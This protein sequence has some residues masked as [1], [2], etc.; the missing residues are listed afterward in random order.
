MIL[1]A[2]TNY[3]KNNDGLVN[4]FTWVG[5][6][7][8]NELITWS[9]GSNNFSAVFGE[10]LA[11]TLMWAILATFTNYFLGMFVAIMIN[12]KGIKFKKLWRGLLV[13]TIAIPQF[14][15]LIYVS[16]LFDSNGII[17]GFL[18]NNN[19]IKE[20]IPFWTD[21]T[22]A[23]IM[24]VLINIWV[25]VPYL[26]L[27]TTGVLMNIPADLYESAKIDGANAFQQYVKITLPYMLFVTGPYLL[28]SFIGNLNNFNVIFLLTGGAPTKIN[29]ATSGGSSGETDLLITWLFKITT[30]DSN[31]KLASVI[32]IIIFIIVAV[33]SLVVYNIMPSNK[34]EEDYS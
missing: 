10:I 23:R 25:G 29:G 34:N 19:I 30:T 14:I 9:S 16:K 18:L 13:L 8:F 32:G 5:L 3:D 21:K 33:L 26:M 7:N 24:V 12:K 2:F 1:V 31:Y 17:N 11:W 4:L 6:D 22:L 27:T 28:T 15:S 20:A